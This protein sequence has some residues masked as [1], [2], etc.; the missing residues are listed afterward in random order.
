MEDNKTKDTSDAEA[1]DEQKKKNE[2]VTETD[3]YSTYFSDVLKNL[4]DNL[5]K[6]REYQKKMDDLLAKLDSPANSRMMTHEV[7]L[8]EN[9]A[10]MQSQIQSNI[11]DIFAVKKAAL[12]YS[13][14]DKSGLDE[15]DATAVLHALR[16]L[17][18][19]TKAT[20]A[21]TDNLGG[22]V[23]NVIMESTK[24]TKSAID[25]EIDARLEADPPEVI[26]NVTPETDLPS[27]P[28]SAIKKA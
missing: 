17:A 27:R 15:S 14:R 19:D 28:D 21:R 23:D 13:F 12:D 4:E 26:P 7:D 6:S 1:L 22:K 20:T 3:A 18:K 16:L 10:S 24:E 25:G 5:S 8:F 2:Y 11:K 9:I